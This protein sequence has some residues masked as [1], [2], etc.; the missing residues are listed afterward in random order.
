MRT[1]GGPNPWSRIAATASAASGRSSSRSAI[2]PRSVAPSATKTGVSPS[3]AILTASL[4]ASGATSAPT[5]VISERFPTLQGVPSERSTTPSPG[6]RWIEALPATSQSRRLASA[7]TAWAT[8][9]SDP[10]SSL[11]A[12]PSIAPAGTP[13]RATTSCTSL[14]P[15]VSVPVLSMATVCTWAAASRNLPPLTRIPSREARPSAAT[16]AVGV[17]STKAHGHPTINIVT[18][19]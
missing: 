16:T 12:W 19:R 10:V 8:G 11:A 14:R 1:I 2:N 6:M 17:A 4:S 3:S 5:C 9:C 15:V 7:K 18:A 13:S